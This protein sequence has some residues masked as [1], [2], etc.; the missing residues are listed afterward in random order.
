MGIFKKPI[1]VQIKRF[2]ID[3]LEFFIY[4]MWIPV[5]DSGEMASER[6]RLMATT[7][8]KTKT[9]PSETKCLVHPFFAEGEFY[10]NYKTTITVKT[11]K[12]R[13]CF[14]LPLTTNA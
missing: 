3:P 8:I 13:C 7:T 9:T 4:L 10:G 14:N 2:V 5:T 6:Q 12:E 11:Y 1:K